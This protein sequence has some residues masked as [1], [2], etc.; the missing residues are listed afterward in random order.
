MSRMVSVNGHTKAGTRGGIPFGY[1]SCTPPESSTRKRCD[2]EHP[3]GVRQVEGDAEAVREPFQRYSTGMTTLSQLASW[4][5]RQGLRTR[6][7]H[8]MLDVR[9]NSRAGPRLFIV[10]SLRGILHNPFY[11]GQVKH[12]DELLPG[13]HEAIVSEDLFQVVQA[14]MKRNSGKSETLHP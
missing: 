6:N 5:N 11:K 10:A 14:T 4:L 12:R 8:R 9:G 2:P 1:E 13:V 7:M 3:G